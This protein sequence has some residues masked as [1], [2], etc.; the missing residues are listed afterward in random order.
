MT[1]VRSLEY[2]LVLS[3]Y[4]CLMLDHCEY[5]HNYFEMILK[6]KKKESTDASRLGY[7]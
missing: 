5:C 7:F 6:E 3:I 2:R 4:L 1:V